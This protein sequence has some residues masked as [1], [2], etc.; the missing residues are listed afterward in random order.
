MHR[1]RSNNIV[2]IHSK[3]FLKQ[4]LSPIRIQVCSSR[5]LFASWAS[6]VYAGP[7]FSSSLYLTWQRRQHDISSA[8][9]E[10][11]PTIPPIQ[12]QI[13]AERWF[14]LK[15]LDTSTGLP[16]P[17]GC[18]RSSVPYWMA[19]S[20][21]G[22]GRHALHADVSYL[23]PMHTVLLPIVNFALAFLLEFLLLL[24]LLLSTLSR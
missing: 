10:S 13:T 18:K 3:W 8:L 21:M 6:T 23:H 20:H 16:G 11:M 9:H 4:V 1:I 24:F 5:R 12:I 22:H 2:F 17:L 15:S 7:V 19:C 14:V